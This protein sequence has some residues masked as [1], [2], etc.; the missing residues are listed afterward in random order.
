MVLLNLC[1]RVMIHTPLGKVHAGI[2]RYSSSENWAHF[3][4]KYFFFFFF[5]E[6]RFSMAFH[7]NIFV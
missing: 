4:V 5:F 2:Y 7:I 3:G 6:N 1:A